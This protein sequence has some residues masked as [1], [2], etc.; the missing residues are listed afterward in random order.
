[1]VKLLLGKGSRVVISDARYI[2]AMF[3]ELSTRH[4]SSMC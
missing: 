2:T 1:M 3:F 4:V